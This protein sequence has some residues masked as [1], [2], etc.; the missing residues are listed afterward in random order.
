MDDIVAGRQHDVRR[1]AAILADQF[2]GAGLVGPVGK[3][4]PHQSAI[5]RP[6][7]P[8]RSARSAP[9]RPGRA[10]DV[11][12]AGGTTGGSATVADRRLRQG[13]RQARA[14]AGPDGGARLIAG[15]RGPEPTA[16]GTGGGRSVNIWAETGPART[17]RQQRG[18]RTAPAP[19]VPR[20]RIHRCHYALESSW[21]C[22]SLKTRQIQASAPVPKT[23][24]GDAQEQNIL[25]QSHASVASGQ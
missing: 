25:D 12:A 7:C 9:A 11:P 13:R 22:F 16:G 19:G 4:P 8:C 18:K 21:S 1:R 17:D 2:E 6:A 10:V 24:G 5:D 15:R 3:D 20:R 23:D 14:G